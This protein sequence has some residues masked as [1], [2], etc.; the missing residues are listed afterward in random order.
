MDKLRWGVPGPTLQRAGRWKLLQLPNKQQRVENCPG[1]AW[2]LSDPS[3]QFPSALGRKWV[4]ISEDRVGPLPCWGCQLVHKEKAKPVDGPWLLCPRTQVSVKTEGFP[5]PR[6]ITL[7]PAIARQP[8][9][10]EKLS[11]SP[12]CQSPPLQTRSVSWYLLFPFF[13]GN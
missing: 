10:Q 9:S 5:R 8:R 3:A 6:S 13:H 2:H 12:E 4:S 11:L 1:G 7:P